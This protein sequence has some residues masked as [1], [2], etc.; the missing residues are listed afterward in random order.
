MH[1]YLQLYIYDFVDNVDFK[2]LTKRVY[3]S[4]LYPFDSCL[5]KMSQAHQLY[6]PYLAHVSEIS[7]HYGHYVDEK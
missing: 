1:I 7:C 4:L 2:V 3:D 5:V 6:Q